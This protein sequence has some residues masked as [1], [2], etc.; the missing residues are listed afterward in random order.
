M[1][2]ADAHAA[3]CIQSIKEEAGGA[4]VHLVH[5]FARQGAEDA[6]KFAP[7]QLSIHRPEQQ[8]LGQAG[9]HLGGGRTGEGQAE[10]GLRGRAV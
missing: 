6:G 9:E 10:E 8:P 5:L 1:E 2:G 4:G 7:A 3:G